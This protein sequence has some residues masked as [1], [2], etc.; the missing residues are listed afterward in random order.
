M[1]GA[2]ARSCRP[3]HLPF[4]RPGRVVEAIAFR[5]A[6]EGRMV[7]FDAGARSRTDG[8][9]VASFPSCSESAKSFFMI[10]AFSHFSARLGLRAKTLSSK[11]SAATPIPASAITIRID[12]MSIMCPVSFERGIKSVRPVWTFCSAQ[13]LEYRLL[14]L[15]AQ[16]SART[17]AP[18]PTRLP[19][20]LATAVSAVRRA[21]RHLHPSGNR[22][23][24]ASDRCCPLGANH[25]VLG[26]ISNPGQRAS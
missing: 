19:R 14:K 6:L 17:D 15:L 7:G 16:I 12:E 1:S 20:A 4:E 23:G 5:C 18:P 13:A 10:S 26:W 8:L 25:L 21:S 2:S 11:A 9:V 24:S 22:F 3:G